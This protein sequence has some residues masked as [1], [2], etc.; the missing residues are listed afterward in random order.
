VATI[1]AG[2]VAPM[3][4]AVAL[5]TYHVVA[6]IIMSATAFFTR[7]PSTLILPIWSVVLVR[8]DTMIF[9]VI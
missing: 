3:I 2:S 5:N 8:L 1:V 4:C 9:I 7:M 6:V